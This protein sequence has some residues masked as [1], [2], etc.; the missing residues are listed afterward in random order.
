MVE[1]HKEGTRSMRSDLYE[2]G[3]FN[4]GNITSPLKLLPE[5]GK[6]GNVEFLD[7]HDSLD[8]IKPRM[9]GDRSN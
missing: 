2:R 3:W 4:V 1:R 5:F 6:V 8:N 7:E 9:D